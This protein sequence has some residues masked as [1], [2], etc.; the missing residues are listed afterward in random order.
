MR[1]SH[2]KENLWKALHYTATKAELAVLALYAQ[3][4]THPCMRAI[5]APKF[6]KV[7][8]LDLGP[9]HQKVYAHM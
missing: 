2:M 8:M 7:N 9:L 4:I 1:F 3:A 5:C 6:E